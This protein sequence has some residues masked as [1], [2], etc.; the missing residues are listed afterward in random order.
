METTAYIALSRQMALR[1]RMDVIAHNVANLNTTGF[2]GEA[3]LLE[4]VIE[5]SAGRDRLAFVQDFATVR[6]LTP[7]PMITTNNPL[8]LAIDGDGYFVVETADGPRYTRA[9]QFQL[10]DAGELVTTAGD[11][12]LGEGGA[13]LVLPSDTQTVVIASDGTMSSPDG[14]LGRIEVV[15]FADEQTLR[16]AGGGLFVTDQA[17]EPGP[18]ATRLVQGTLETSN[19]QP[20]LEMTEMMS[21]SRA[22]QSTQRLIETHHELQRQ[23]IQRTLD[24]NK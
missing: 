15:A 4:P 24:F 12:V 8:D 11:P 21:T 14:V 16:R 1:R 2:K 5:R 19:V 9:G 6:N 13:R 23:A 18:E 20:V 10:N 22:Y 17:P 7:G 3:M